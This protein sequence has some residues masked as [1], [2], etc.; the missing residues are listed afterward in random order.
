[1]KYVVSEHLEGA[2]KAASTRLRAATHH[3]GSRSGG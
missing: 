2:A 3:A 1:M